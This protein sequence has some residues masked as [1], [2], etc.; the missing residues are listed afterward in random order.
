[1]EMTR[2][3]KCYMKRLRGP[4][5]RCRWTPQRIR[6]ER[7]KLDLTQDMFAHGI[8]VAWVTVARWEALTGGSQPSKRSLALLESK[9]AEWESERR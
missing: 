3:R 4:C 2:C 1:M 7:A 9:T 6:R 8:G 5:L